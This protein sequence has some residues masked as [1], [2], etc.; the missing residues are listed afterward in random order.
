MNEAWTSLIDPYEIAGPH[1]PGGTGTVVD[2]TDRL[3]GNEVA[4]ISGVATGDLYVTRRGRDDVG[5]TPRVITSMG[6]TDL[7]I[8]SRLKGPS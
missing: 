7:N 1:G 5:C 3:F 2:A 4:M 8:C 6:T